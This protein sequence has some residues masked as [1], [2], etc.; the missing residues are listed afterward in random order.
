MEEIAK[1]VIQGKWGNG[2]ERKNRLAAAGYD[3]NTVQG[4][5]NSLLSGKPVSTPTTQSTNT[6]GATGSNLATQYANQAGANLVSQNPVF[7]EVLP[8]EQV[9]KQMLPSA[10]AQAIQQVSPE[11][12]RQ[13]NTSLSNYYKG[14][15]GR[16]GGM[17]GFGGAGTLEAEAERNKKSQ[18][19][20]W[21][22]Q[23]QSA[24]REWYDNTATSYNK[25][26]EL[27]NVGNVPAIPTWSDFMKT[28][29]NSIQSPSY[30][31]MAGATI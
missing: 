1:Q 11:I 31:S 24:V 22:N 26:L 13:L 14:L 7:S 12:Q 27:G 18:T 15:A 29:G 4:M 9:W 19:M 16:G 20:D 17:F 21:L 6:A 8:F 23:G 25:G 30:S 3:Y 2:T 5:V 28:Y 10:E